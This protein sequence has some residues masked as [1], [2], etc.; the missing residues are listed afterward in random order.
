M[1]TESFYMKGFDSKN[2]ASIVTY[3]ICRLHN[4]KYAK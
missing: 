1:D 3:A 2:R 4:D